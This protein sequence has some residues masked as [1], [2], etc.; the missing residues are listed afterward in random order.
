MALP[1]S[2]SGWPRDEVRPDE[3]LEQLKVS[4]GLSFKHPRFASR[5]TLTQKFTE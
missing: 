3:T 2:A 1:L 5:K 4:L